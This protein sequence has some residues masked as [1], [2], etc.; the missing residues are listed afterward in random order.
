MVEQW[1]IAAEMS[2]CEWSGDDRYDSEVGSDEDVDPEGCTARNALEQVA[3]KE[4]RINSKP[5]M[6]SARPFGDKGLMG[7][8]M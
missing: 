8:W 5:K 7:L 2:D 4:L 6:V 1:L 3:Y